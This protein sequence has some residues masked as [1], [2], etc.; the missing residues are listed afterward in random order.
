MKRQFDQLNEFTQ[1]LVR[2]SAETRK[3]FWS[4]ADA[5]SVDKWQETTQPYRAYLW[6]EVIGRLP[7]AAL[8]GNPR[9]VRVY[10]EAAF[11]GYDIQIDVLPYLF[12]SG[13]LLVPRDIKPGQRRAV[14]VCQHG[15]EGVP[16][17]TIRGD[18]EGFKYYQAFARR[19]VEK[20]YVVYAPQNPY[21]GKDAFRLLQRKGNPLGLSLFSFITAQHQRTLAWLATLPFVDANRIG[22]Y[23][24][25]YGGKTA[26]RVPALL[27]Q[28]ALSICSGD[29][30]EWIAKN[31]SLDYAGSYMYTLE[32]EMPEFDLGNTFNHA[33]MAWLIAPRPFMVERGHND[34]V[35]IDEW[36]ASEYAK[37]RRLYAHLGIPQLTEIEFFSGPHQ[38]HGVG[39]FAFLDHHLRH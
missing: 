14:V 5:S 35:G 8:H 39:T 26:M 6:D 30:N 20:G 37:V 4:K 2:R 33:E 18:G 28:Y 10:D 23:G 32:W 16:Q 12:A 9:S 15:L 11:Q 19:L 7:P 34:A 3:T 21:R 36:V 27:P 1:R 24:L 31:T 22:F 17:D 25:S 29:F 13:I 38:I